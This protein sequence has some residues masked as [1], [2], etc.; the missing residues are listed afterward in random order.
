MV[1]G[2]T[3]DG[4]NDA[5]ALAK[6]QIGIAVEGATD[7]A[8]AAADIILTRPG[9][10]PIY[11]AILESRRIFKRLKSYVIYRIC[12][13]VQVVA[14]LCIVSFGFDLIFPALYI[15]LLALFHDLTIVT[16]AYDRQTPSPTPEIPTVKMLIFMAYILGLALTTSTTL[17]F[18]YGD[19]FGLSSQF[20]QTP[21]DGILVTEYMV[22]HVPP[23]HQLVRHHHL[24]RAHARLLLPLQ[25]RA[26]AHRLRHPLPGHRQPRMLL[27]H[28]RHDRAAQPQGYGHRLDVRPR[29]APHL[30]CDQDGCHLRPRRPPRRRPRRL[31][32]QLRVLLRRGAP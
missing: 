30:G 13:T 27:R 28:L 14:F 4:V 19:R 21:E 12:C 2:M 23:A 25:P 3:G 29:V 1:V 5:P 15:I 32:Q 22:R 16:I 11:T 24:L 7:A 31:A 10:S 6:A 18:C 17:L 9:L 8:Q 20:A 26:G